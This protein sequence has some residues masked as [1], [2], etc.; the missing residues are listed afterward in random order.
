M[1]N[2]KQFNSFTYNTKCNIWRISFM[3]KDKDYDIRNY[4]SDEY[5]IISYN[6][7]KTY[8]GICINELNRYYGE[9]CTMYYVWKN[10]LKSD[11][12]G[13]DQYRRQWHDINFE[14]INKD[15]IQVYSYWIDDILPVSKL[16]YDD[17]GGFLYSLIL[18]IKYYYPE[19][20]DKLNYLL[21]KHNLI[22]NHIN[23][24]VCKWDIFE[25]ICN[26]VFG[27][28]DH[29]M[30]NNQWQNKEVIENYYTFNYNLHKHFGFNNKSTI[31]AI[32]IRNIVLCFEILFGLIYNVISE[33]FEHG[34]ESNYYILYKCNSIN[35]C[36]NIIKTYSYNVGNG[37]NY[38]FVK[39]GK[40]FVKYVNE[41]NINLDN[42]PYIYSYDDNSIIHYFPPGYNYYNAKNG[43]KI[44]LNS[45]EYV[46]SENSIEL[47]KGNY[48]IKTI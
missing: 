15:K 4:Y 30:P 3:N 39:N 40:Q 2:Q 10:N 9:L 41:L 44:E 14:N 16:E 42:Y 24:F 37:I 27:F 26:I 11:I 46:Y 1:K 45:N 43:N 5:N 6:N 17:L 19:Y 28:L 29:I 13:F 47:E 32:N 22:K 38:I 12:V 35:D 34:K 20:S 21:F 8:D 18:Y 23:I 25:K 31:L 7:D 36:I 33:S 48:I